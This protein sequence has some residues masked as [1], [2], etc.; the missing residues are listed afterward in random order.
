MEEKVYR[1]AQEVLG[2]RIKAKGEREEGEVQKERVSETKYALCKY[3]VSLF[4]KF[5]FLAIIF[6]QVER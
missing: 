3:T 2:T 5:F 6:K 1:Q 4:P